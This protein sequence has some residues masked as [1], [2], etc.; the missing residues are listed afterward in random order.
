MFEV[1]RGR[2]AVVCANFIGFGQW[3]GTPLCWYRCPGVFRKN[4]L[5]YLYSCLENAGNLGNT[6]VGA[7]SILS[8][9]R[10]FVTGGFVAEMQDGHKIIYAFFNF[11]CA[12]HNHQ[13]ET[14]FLKLFKGGCIS[15]II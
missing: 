3:F 1:M 11:G 2:C 4:Q 9:F 5:Q 10:F 7:V 6:R 15:C 14:I 8:L 13:R 12:I